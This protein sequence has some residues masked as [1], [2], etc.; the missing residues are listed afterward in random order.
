[1]P[2]LMPF[3]VGR[4]VAEIEIVEQLRLRA[5]SGG[6]GRPCEKSDPSPA[7]PGLSAISS[8]E[9]PVRDG[10]DEEQ[11]RGPIEGVH[12]PQP[13]KRRRPGI[14]LDVRHAVF[15]ARSGERAARVLDPQWFHA[16]LMRIA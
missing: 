4:Q 16:F 5:P 12:V 15:V 9:R 13:V 1:M 7:A 14:G 3:A 6:T 2:S 8:A 11:L 10:A